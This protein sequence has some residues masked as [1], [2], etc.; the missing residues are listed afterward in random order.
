M[1]S[2]SAYLKKHNLSQEEFGRSLKV[3]KGLVWQWLNGR[4]RITGDM[5]VRIEHVTGGEVKR[6]HLLP[7]LYHGMEHS[8]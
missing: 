6:Q 5:A 1:K 8:N 3:S 7:E 4:T 2:L